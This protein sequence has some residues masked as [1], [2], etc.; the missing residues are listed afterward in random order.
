MNYWQKNWFKIVFPNRKRNFL[1]FNNSY[2]NS[3][4]TINNIMEISSINSCD[5]VLV[6]NLYF[7][8]NRGSQRPEISNANLCVP[9]G[10]IYGLLGPSGCG[11]TTLLRCIIGRLKPRKGLVRVFDTQPGMYSISF[12]WWT[13]LMSSHF[14]ITNF[15]FDL[16]LKLSFDLN[17][18]FGFLF[19]Y[20]SD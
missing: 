4:N 13:F 14:F 12:F 10:V 5:G 3:Y 9:R 11:K 6:Q 7:G 19:D 8:Y 2:N 18:K 17:F 1:L 20:F 15:S 16:N